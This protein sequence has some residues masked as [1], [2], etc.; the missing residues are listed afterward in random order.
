MVKLALKQLIKKKIMFFL[1]LFFLGGVLPLLSVFLYRNFEN[2]Y[3]EFISN[4]TLQMHVWIPMFSAWWG[5][6]LFNDFFENEGNELLYMYYRPVHL[7]VEQLFVSLLYVIAL[8]LFF[9]LFQHFVDVE[10]FLLVQLIA[11]S[12]VIS[13]AVY[14]LCFA[15]QKTGVG[16]L[17]AVTYCIYLNLFDSL[18]LLKFLSIFPESSIADTENVGVIKI[19]VFISFL[20]LCS[21]FLSSKI[22]RTFK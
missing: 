22:C 20:F 9:S 10:K 13:S 14:F 3:E 5:I 21:G 11:E 15:F 12:L 17:M 18:K 6:L 8:I 7:L 4:I 2:D 1:P 19:S 16:L